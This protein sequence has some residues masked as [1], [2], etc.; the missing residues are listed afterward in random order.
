M[1]LEAFENIIEAVVDG[2]EGFLFTEE[3]MTVFAV[4]RSLDG[5]STSFHHI[6]YSVLIGISLKV[7]LSHVDDARLLFI[8]LFMRKSTSARWFRLAKL[9]YPQIRDLVIACGA[10]CDPDV[11]FAEN[12]EAI[13]TLDE[14][15][16]M[17]SLD[18][19]KEIARVFCGEIEKISGKNVS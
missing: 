6:L 13:T 2:G 4:Y 12:E 17:M 14:A 9:N 19:L 16:E 7:L 1:Y 8:R 15:F 18:E 10:L 11:R 5:T 3:E